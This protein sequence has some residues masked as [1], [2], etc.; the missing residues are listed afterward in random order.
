MN[1]SFDDNC[2]VK[3]RLIPGRVIKGFRRCGMA[4][5]IS[6]RRAAFSQRGN[7]TSINK[8]IC[9]LPAPFGFAAVFSRAAFISDGAGLEISKMHRQSGNL[10]APDRGGV[11]PGKRSGYEFLVSFSNKQ[12]IKKQ[13]EPSRS[14]GAVFLVLRRLNIASK[15][16]G[17][18]PSDKASGSVDTCGISGFRQRSM[19]EK[20]PARRAIFSCWSTNAILQ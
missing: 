12:A 14:Q 16:R 7:D 4:E 19:T 6:G 20:R 3:P 10:N 1:N 2:E 18:S 9:A 5:K 8:K 15:R 13:P 17:F 11:L